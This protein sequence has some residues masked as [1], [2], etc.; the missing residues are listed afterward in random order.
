MYGGARPGFGGRHEGAVFQD[1]IHCFGGGSPEGEVGLSVLQDFGTEGHPVA[2]P[3]SA[4]SS[5][6]SRG[7]VFTSTAM[8]RGFKVYTP[9][10]LKKP[11]GF[12]PAE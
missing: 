9:P 7:W 5:T 11:S 4:S 1:H 8:E 6:V 12:R 3:Q 10:G 2:T